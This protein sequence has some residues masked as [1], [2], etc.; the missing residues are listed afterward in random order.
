MRRTEG[1]RYRVLVDSMKSILVLATL[2]LLLSACAQ[3]DAPPAV[4]YSSP[5]GQIRFS[6]EVVADVKADDPLNDEQVA[7]IRYAV[8]FSDSLGQPLTK[9]FYHDVYGMEGEPAEL[10]DLARWFAWSP[11]EDF[12]IL[13][14]EGWMTAPGTASAPV[15]NLNPQFRWTMA[16]IAIDDQVWI[17]SLRIVGNEIFDCAYSVVMFDGRTGETR[18][19]KAA[20]SPTGYTISILDEKVIRIQSLPDNCA[21]EDQRA[22][23]VPACW[24]FSLETFILAQEECG[25]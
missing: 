23:F 13:P 9:V 10:S 12:V 6:F 5:S 17:D 14:A 20:E 4:Q 8:T 24:Q 19:I 15:V 21:S 3:R 18:A 22:A 2:A 16:A 1:A 11:R 7:F 25:L